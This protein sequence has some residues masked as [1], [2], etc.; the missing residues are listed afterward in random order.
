MNILIVDDTQM[1]LDDIRTFLT[2]YFLIPNIKFEI[3]E[4]SSFAGV[5]NRIEKTKFDL[6][7]LDA[8][9]GSEG[10]GYQLIPVLVKNNEH[11]KIVSCS[12]LMA[13]NE[14][15]I[16]KGAHIS[17]NKEKIVDH[18]DENGSYRKKIVEEIKNLLLF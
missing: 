1:Y 5:R 6:V 11:I 10:W 17:L 16:K 12:T 3:Q 15:A 8:D 18:E 7:M 2:T 14:E 4:A 9:M 13:Y